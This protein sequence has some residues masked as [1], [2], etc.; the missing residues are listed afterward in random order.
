MALPQMPLCH[1]PLRAACPTAQPLHPRR[2][3]SLRRATALRC[4][5]PFARLRLS[6]REMLNRIASLASHGA[7]VPSSHRRN[8]STFA[9]RASA[10]FSAN[11]SSAMAMTYACPSAMTVRTPGSLQPG[12]SV[13]GATGAAWVLLA[14][15]TVQVSTPSVMVSTAAARSAHRSPTTF[16]TVHLRPFARRLRPQRWL[17]RS[18]LWLLW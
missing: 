7:S 15:G 1:L 3:A 6:R 14:R 18:V 9:I 17:S 2:Q 13:K 10:S 16:T 8:Q 4:L 5:Q 12:T 11:S